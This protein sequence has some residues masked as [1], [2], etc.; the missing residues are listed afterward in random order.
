M[1]YNHKIHT[2]FRTII[3]IFQNKKLSLKLPYILLDSGNIFSDRHK[4]ILFFL[5]V[6]GEVGRFWKYVPFAF[7]NK[8]RVAIIENG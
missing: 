5:E 1:H 3:G 2:P 7:G 6:C 4:C 8:K